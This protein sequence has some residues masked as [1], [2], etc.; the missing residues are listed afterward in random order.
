MLL[1]HLIKRYFIWMALSYII[2]ATV[3]YTFILIPQRNTIQQY[4]DEKAAMEYTYMKITSSP[5]FLKSLDETVRL[6]SLK[7]NDFLWLDSEGIDAGLALYNH[8]YKLS[9]KSNV[10]LLE[11]SLEEKTSSKQ[12]KEGN[13]Y[14]RWKVRFT[15]SFPDIVSLI[16]DI[17]QSRS[18]LIV[19]EITISKEGSDTKPLYEMVIYGIK[20]EALG[21][22]KDEKEN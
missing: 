12:D 13:L 16:N 10:E 19:K 3:I 20:K 4:K 1:K 15:G 5:A 2:I 22:K 17:E 14:Y 8:L 6:A 11:V 7:T 9:K 21:E 18:F